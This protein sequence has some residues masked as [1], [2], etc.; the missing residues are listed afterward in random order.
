MGYKVQLTLEKNYKIRIKTNHD[1][2]ML[3]MKDEF[4]Y[5]VKGYFWMGKYK[6][7]MWD[8]K[9]HFITDACLMPFG[10]LLDFLRVHKKIFPNLQL[11][12]DDGIKNL[13]KGYPI[14]IKFDL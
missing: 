6:A 13:F 5:H 2:Y 9:A 14:D 11:E 1:T 3:K 12:P 10:L 8:G 4:S 7:G